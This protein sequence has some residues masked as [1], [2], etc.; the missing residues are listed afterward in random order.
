MD[1]MELNAKAW[2]TLLL[3][4][5]LKQAAAQI[6]QT[7]PVQTRD[8]VQINAPVDVVWRAL[9]DVAGWPERYDFIRE[10]QPPTDLRANELFRWR[11][12]KLRLTSTI[13]TVT[14][15][16]TL[17]W[18]GRRYGVTVRHY[19]HFQP[20][21]EGGTLV[22]SEESQRGLLVSLLKQRFRRSLREGSRKWL[23]QLKAY[24]ERTQPSTG[25]GGSITY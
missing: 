11:T 19:W 7:A 24:S 14:P 3:A 13:L 2:L 5:L 25:V 1:T 21:P 18:Q 17:G 4:G 10:T 9:S 22:V 20:T 8:T 6:N 15:R 12:T 23:H 16:Q